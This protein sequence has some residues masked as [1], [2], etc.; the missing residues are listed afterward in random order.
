V[1]GPDG[2]GAGIGEIRDCTAGVAGT[3]AGAIEVVWMGA[4]SIGDCTTGACR[5]SVGIPLIAIPFAG[6][7]FI[8]IP[9]EGMP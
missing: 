4:G 3:G 2:I 6:M 8:G 1:I 9:F 7:L 5:Y